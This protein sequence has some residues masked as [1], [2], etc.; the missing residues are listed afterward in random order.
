MPKSTDLCIV[1]GCKNKRKSRGV[2]IACYFAARRQ[3]K[4]G[5]ITEEQLIKRRLLLKANRTGRP[6]SS[7]MA[8]MIGGGK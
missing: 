3:M 7:R 6:A 1:P 4:A 2:C 5:S 8:K